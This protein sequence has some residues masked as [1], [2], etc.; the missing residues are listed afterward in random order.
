MSSHRTH[1]TMAN[2]IACNALDADRQA[3]Y[4]QRT[5]VHPPVELVTVCGRC[6]IRAQRHVTVCLGTKVFF[7]DGGRGLDHPGHGETPVGPEGRR[8][9]AESGPCF[10]PTRLNFF[11]FVVR[12]RDFSQKGGSLTS[13]ARRSNRVRGL[14]RMPAG[15][16]E[17]GAGWRD[18]ERVAL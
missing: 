11:R 14:R 17:T 1:A 8:R 5:Q 10:S 3:L 12:I 6:S 7:R 4:T 15:K 2:P 18:G 13:G 9:G 16:Q